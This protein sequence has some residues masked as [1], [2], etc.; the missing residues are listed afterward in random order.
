MLDYKIGA[1]H[2]EHRLARLKSARSHA[3]Q[4]ATSSLYPTPMPSSLAG[5]SALYDAMMQ[6]SANSSTATA[7]A[8]ATSADDAYANTYGLSSSA[9][10][11]AAASVGATSAGARMGGASGSASTGQQAD[12][13][14]YGDE[15]RRKKMKKTHAAEQYVC[16]TCGRTDSPEWRKGPQGPKT[17]CNACGLR[18]AKLLRIRQE[19]ENAA[20]EAAAGNAGSS[21]SSGAGSEPAAGSGGTEG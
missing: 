16:K 13:A 9:V 17:L 7:T 3:H 6:P 20:M 12:A 21:A 4:S 11:A 18:W 10:A 19:E 14:E 2:L 8:T 1:Q 15:A 5:P